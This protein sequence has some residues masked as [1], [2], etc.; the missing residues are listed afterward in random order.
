MSNMLISRT[1]STFLR[2][3]LINTNTLLSTNIIINNKNVRTNLF[4]TLN[5]TNLTK[6][7][8]TNNRSSRVININQKCMYT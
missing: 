8:L 1:T 7:I 3:K 4:H 2:R 6:N 5:N